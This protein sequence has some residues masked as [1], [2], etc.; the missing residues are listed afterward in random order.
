MTQQDVLHFAYLPN[1]F[2][3]AGGPNG[4]IT[5]YNGYQAVKEIGGGH[6]LPNGEYKPRN[7]KLLHRIDDSGSEDHGKIDV[8]WGQIQ[9]HMQPRCNS[10]DE[11]SRRDLRTFCMCVR[12]RKDGSNVLLSG[13]GDGRVLEWEILEPQYDI[14]KLGNVIPADDQTPPQDYDA[15]GEEGGGGGGG[16]GGGARSPRADWEAVWVKEHGEKY[17]VLQQRDPVAWQDLLEEEWSIHFKEESAGGLQQNVDATHKPKREDDV[18]A[19]TAIDTDPQHP[20]KFIA[21]SKQNDVWEID[22]DPRVL[23]EGQSADVYGLA[24]HPTMDDI[25]ASGC[26]DGSVYLWD[27]DA[28]KEDGPRSIKAFQVRRQSAQRPE[29]C[30]AGEL[31]KVKAVAFSAAND[32]RGGLF[33]LSTAGVISERPPV[34]ID[35]VEQEEPDHPDLGGGLQVFTCGATANDPFFVTESDGEMTKEDCAKFYDDHCIWE[36]KDS[37]EVID[38]IKFSPSV[39]FL[40]A[41]SHD[42]YIYVYRIDWEGD[43]PTIKLHTKCKGHSSYVTHIDW[44]ADSSV[45]LSNSGDYELLYWALNKQRT[46]FELYSHSSTRNAN[47]RDVEWA[48]WTGVLGF[49]AMGIW[50]EGM[51]GTDYNALHRSE[52]HGGKRFCVGSTDDGLVRLFNHP[53]VIDKAPH[54]RFRGHSSHVQNVRF[55]TGDKRVVSAGGRDGSMMQWVTRGVT[56]PVKTAGGELKKLVKDSRAKPAPTR[57]MGRP[58]AR[59]RAATPEEPQPPTLE[60]LQQQEA[61]NREMLKEKEKEIRRLKSKLTKAQKGGRRQK[62]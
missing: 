50:Q 6:W 36:K 40:A 10:E 54:H 4:S 57:A 30:E 11:R 60:E 19:Y 51:D 3:A 5:L 15:E 18:P 55:L 8:D 21:G 49:E 20:D 38:D 25:Y 13:A 39:E 14:D 61:L 56:K 44:S 23:V 35:G 46:T 12:T 58:G 9:A 24:P 41:A 48:S 52:D 34:V 47:L 7:G 62:R 53:V 2:V 16:G 26:E 28:S 17:A 43:G 27:G 33:A 32:E 59:A 1:G 31:L 45:L 22:K 42:N 37:N 29:G